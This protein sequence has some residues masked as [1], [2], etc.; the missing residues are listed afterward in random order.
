MLAVNHW[1]AAA[2]GRAIYPTA[3]KSMIRF[4]KFS[5]F[6]SYGQMKN[7]QANNKK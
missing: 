4:F 1:D 5:L 7:N 2:A 3:S 6:P